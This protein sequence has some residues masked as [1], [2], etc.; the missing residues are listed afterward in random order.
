ML[1]VQDRCFSAPCALAHTAWY[2]EV[3][4]G[5]MDVYVSLD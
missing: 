5:S 1:S 2:A 3:V 4:K